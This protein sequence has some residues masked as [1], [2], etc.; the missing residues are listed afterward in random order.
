ML[1]KHYYQA[2]NAW[3]V[4]FAPANDPDIAYYNEF[5]KYLGD[6]QRAA[7]VKLDERN[8]LFLVPPSD[9]SEKVLKVPGKLSISGVVLRLDPPGSSY[10][11][12]PQNEKRE[13]PFSS[14]QNDSVYQMPISPSSTYLPAGPE[15][16][17][18]SQ[19]VIRN[20]T[21][22]TAGQPCSSFPRPMQD[23]A[24]S[25]YTPDVVPTVPLN[26]SG[27][28]A[29]VS[30]NPSSGLPSRQLAELA[31]A[32]LGQQGQLTGVSSTEEYR[33]SGNVNQAGYSYKSQENYGFPG[34]EVSPEF[35]FQQ[36]QQQQ[37]QQ[38]QGIAAQAVAMANQQFQNTE[39]DDE[40]DPQK[41]LQAT[42]QLAAALLQQ[43]QQSKGT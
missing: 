2:V 31:S 26:G 24:H 37:Q 16:A 3:V 36:L 33:P 6:K 43:I 19:P 15:Y 5:M 39:Q 32:F 20:V 7:V 35:Q 9:F 41:R 42:L 28:W 14:F 38:Q 21:Q 40:A 4:F 1:A 25:S 17:R 30:E 22:Q 11:S 29:P 10:D 13:T 12:L 27:K 23:A 18:N 34:E 8:T